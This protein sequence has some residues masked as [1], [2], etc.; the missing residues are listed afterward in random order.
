MEKRAY[1]YREAAHYLGISVELLKVD[2]RDGKVPVHYWNSKPLFYKEE[3]D[4]LLNQLPAE[5]SA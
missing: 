2:V 4:E 3:M 1:S 5:R